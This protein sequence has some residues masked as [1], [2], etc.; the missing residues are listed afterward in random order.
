MPIQTSVAVGQFLYRLFVLFGR[1]AGRGG[2]VPGDGLEVVS[3]VKANPAPGE[4]HTSSP[5]MIMDASTHA[6]HHQCTE[7]MC[8]LPHA[9]PP[10]LPLIAVVVT[11]STSNCVDVEDSGKTVHP[12]SMMKMPS[13]AWSVLTQL[14]SVCTSCTE[15]T[16]LH[17]RAVRLRQTACTCGSN[18]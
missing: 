1:S 5:N 13:L 8:Y 12:R 10:R 17:F 16:G 3:S 18:V 9:Y 14:I 11:A 4:A 7:N 2:V 15:I 6:R